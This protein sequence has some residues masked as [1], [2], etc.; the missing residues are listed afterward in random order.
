MP[1]SKLYSFS[2]FYGYSRY[3]C[4][5]TDGDAH[6]VADRLKGW[7]TSIIPC[8]REICGSVGNL[9]VITDAPYGVIMDAMAEVAKGA[10]LA[11]H[12]HNY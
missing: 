9:R 11:E 2:G 12:H 7:H 5:Y 10:V 4:F 3:F 8:P 1:R 6:A